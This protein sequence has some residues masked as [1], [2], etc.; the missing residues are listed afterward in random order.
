MSTLLDAYAIIAFLR[1]EPAAGDVRR[2]LE[3]EEVWT[4]AVNAGEVIDRMARLF[5][6]DDDD[7]EASL[8]MLGIAVHGIDRTVGLDAGRIRAEQYHRTHCAVSLA[9]CIAVAAALDAGASLATSDPHLAD[10][11]YAMGVML[12]P[13]PDSKGNLPEPSLD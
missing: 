11:A 3:H 7:V 10:V 4:T 1:G 9:D 2:I 8:E 5:E 13:L 12:V 6:V